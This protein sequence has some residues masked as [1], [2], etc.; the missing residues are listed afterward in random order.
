MK[1]TVKINKVKNVFL[2][3]DNRDIVRQYT[4]AVVALSLLLVST[5]AWFSFVR[6]NTGSLPTLEVINPDN[7]N[8]VLYHQIFDTNG[9]LTSE[10]LET[11]LVISNFVPGQTECYRFEITNS[12]SVE[13]T[14]SATINNVNAD[15]LASSG[16]P[17][18]DIEL[19]KVI[20]L[21]DVYATGNTGTPIIESSV[22]KV[23]DIN[24]NGESLYNLYSTGSDT[25]IKLIQN[26]VIS[27]GQ[28][29]NVY[30]KFH[31]VKE[32]NNYYQF[33]SLKIESISL[34]KA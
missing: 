20:E 19:A 23:D 13:S 7:V 28:I 30:F 15:F 17:Q 18:P 22:L 8:T 26:I 5:F 6:L 12:N 25:D 34:S 14:V 21:M 24:P 10:E 11:E 9:N 31:M 32:A 29:V 1:I 4:L 16:E 3:P 27:P 2:S 33:K